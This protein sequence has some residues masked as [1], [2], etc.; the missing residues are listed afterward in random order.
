MHLLVPAHLVGRQRRHQEHAHRQC[1]R[2][3]SD[4]RPSSK[5][6]TAQEKEGRQPEGHPVKAKLHPVDRQLIDHRKSREYQGHTLKIDV[7]QPLH[8]Q[9]IRLHHNIHIVGLRL[10]PQICVSQ[11]PRIVV[12]DIQLVL[13]V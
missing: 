4:L 2:Q 9:I 6:L 11:H 7:G 5:Q 1:R 13:D 8:L 3:K 10:H 12:P